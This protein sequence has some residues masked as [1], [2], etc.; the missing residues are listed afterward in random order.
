MIQDTKR[1]IARLA[2]LTVLA[3]SLTACSADTNDAAAET[4]FLNGM[5]PHH[6]DAVAMADIALERAEHPEIRELAQNIKRDQEREIEQMQRILG[7]DIATPS[8]GGHGGHAGMVMPA[9]EI[10]AL[11]TAQPFDQ[12]FIDAM[13]PHHESAIKSAQE[14]KDKA[15]RQEVK[16]LAE[17]I[18]TAQEREIAQMRE[19]R[20]QWYGS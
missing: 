11:R 1:M 2:M 19:W 13:I 9:G 20:R 10:E 5:V 16:T 18:I 7:D 15:K 8:A 6:Q 3:I 4:T 12:A 14:V 17:N